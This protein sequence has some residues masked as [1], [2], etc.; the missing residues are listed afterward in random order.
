MQMSDQEKDQQ[1]KGRMV[2]LLMVVFF[3]V[4]MLVVIM[5][6]KLNWKPTGDSYG[7]LVKPPLEISNPNHLMDSSGKT[8]PALLWKDKWSI[9]YISENC[10]DVCRT[11]LHDMRQLHASLYK[12]IIRV[13]K[14]W[15]TNQQD[16]SN[17]KGDYPDMIVINQPRDDVNALMRQFKQEGETDKNVNQF[18]FV[19]PLGF[20]MMQYTIDISLANVRKDLVRLLKSSWAG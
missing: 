1:R 11:R 10:D 9:V 2:L 12:D 6:F 19:D 14:V 20:Y 8:L 15:I 16:V 7:T 18:Y 5:M 3:M 17:I 13:Q 4:P